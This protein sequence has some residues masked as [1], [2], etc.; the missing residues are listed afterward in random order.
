[1]NLQQEA[2]E[3]GRKAISA[4]NDGYITESQ[5]YDVLGEAQRLRD[6]EESQWMELHRHNV[7]KI[8]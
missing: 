3:L 7:S 2:Q 8:A 4:R 1:M 5:M 6:L